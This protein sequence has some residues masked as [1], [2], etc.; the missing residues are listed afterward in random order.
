MLLGEF[1]ALAT[2]FLWSGSA[3]AFTEAS[4]TVGSSLVNITRMIIGEFLLLITVLFLSVNYN[5]SGSQYANLVI[6]GII[7]IAVGDAF[8]FKAFEL[9]GARLS[10]LLMCLAPIIAAF[11]AY[12]FL[13][14]NISNWGIVGVVVTFIGILLVLIQK[15]DSNIKKNKHIYKGIFF[16]FMAAVGQGAGLIFAKLAFNEGEINGFFATFIRLGASL[17][18]FYPIL[19]FSNKLKNPIKKF[20][21]NKKAFVYSSVGAVIGP[22]LGIT[23]SLIAISHTYVGVASTLMS[24]V[25]IIMLPIV[26]IFYKEKLSFRSIV[27][28]VVA[29]AGITIL[30]LMN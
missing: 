20:K 26:W 14:E 15:Q 23:L 18:L 11:F 17:I 28:A 29:V 25:P 8:L 10:M 16:A 24:T 4:R 27:G 13:N 1:A 7:G 2:A 3:I 30:F 6:S 19:F 12:I 5:I 21:N 9:I 22:Y